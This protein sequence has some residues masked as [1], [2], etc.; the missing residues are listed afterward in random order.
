MGDYMY[1]TMEHYSKIF[2]FVYTNMIKVGELSGSLEKSLGQAIKYLDNTENLNSKLKKILIPNIAMLV[3]TLIFLIICV[4]VGVPAVQNLFDSIGSKDELPFLTLCFSNFINKIAENWK[5]IVVTLILIILVLKIYFS[6]KIGRYKLDRFKYCMP[7]FGKLNYMVDFSRVLKCFAINIENGTR[8]QNALEISKNVVKNKVIVSMLN[9]AIDN[10]Y[11]GKS[12]IEPFEKSKFAN[13]ISIE[14]LKV[15]M[16]T[17]LIEMT[18][19]LLEFIN[20]DIENT[21][22]KITTIL[23]E[24]AYAMVGIVLIFFVLIVLV[25]CIQIYMG[26]FMFS[27]YSF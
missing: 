4:T 7:I 25:P 6:S 13:K 24:V 3:G 21:L 5:M 20:T 19:K 15:G 16:Q 27:A 9:V 14:M 8:I 2:P 1:T 22:D 10:S 18:N 23:P 26:G 11:V 12:W 17:D